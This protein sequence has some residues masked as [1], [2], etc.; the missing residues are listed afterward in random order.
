MPDEQESTSPAPEN[1]NPVPASE[2]HGAGCD[3]PGCACSKAGDQTP[4]EK[5]ESDAI[6]AADPG[7]RSLSQALGTSFL[8]LKLVMA[9]VFGFFLLDCVTYVDEEAVAVKMRFGAFVTEGENGPIRIYRAGEPV[10]VL[11]EPIESLVTVKIEREPIVIDKLFWPRSGPQVMGEEAQDLESSQTLNVERAGYNLTGDRNVVHTTWEIRYRVDATD[12]RAYLLATARSAKPEAKL[13]ILRNEADPAALPEDQ[14]L[15]PEDIVRAAAAGIINRALAGMAVDDFIRSEKAGDVVKAIQRDLINELEI[16][17]YGDIGVEIISVSNLRK[18]P[19]G[20][21][22][23][24]FAEVTAALN[25]RQ[26]KIQDADSRRRQILQEARSRAQRLENDASVYKEQ[27][28]ARARADAEYL[29][30]L[31]V[32][33]PILEAEDIAHW[34]RLASALSAGTSPAAKH[35]RQRMQPAALEI[36]KAV[37]QSRQATEEQKAAMLEQIQRLQTAEDLYDPKVFPTSALPPQAAPMLARREKRISLGDE[38]GLFTREKQ[39]LARLLLQSVVGDAIKPIES[40]KTDA[41]SL[42]IF[43]AQNRFRRIREALE[44]VE[45]QLI[46]PGVRSVLIL[47]PRPPNPLDEDEGRN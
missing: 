1:E 22:Q 46:Q 14:Y 35:V 28:V 2:E 13:L 8:L 38:E 23:P 9:A 5:R 32:A 10:F 4:E 39:M 6:I 3:D 17:T 16:G 31:I 19:P 47:A 37:A 40:I 44:R 45:V 12:P 30:N 15:T 25:Q 7:A 27:V 20:F 43:L 29:T 26:S 42:R 21:V 33:A 18:S 34:D 41:A 24:A 11:P 36:F